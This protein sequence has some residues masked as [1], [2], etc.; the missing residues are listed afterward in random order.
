MLN[1]KLAALTMA[2]AITGC[3]Q[4]SETTATA[5]AATSAAELSSWVVSESVDPITDA[6][7]I[8]VAQPAEQHGDFQL[9]IECTGG[10]SSVSLWGD[11]FT[12]TTRGDSESYSVSYRFDAKPGVQFADW[13]ALDHWASP[14]DEAAF[15]RE[16]LGSKTLYARVDSD[17]METSEGKF[18]L[19]GLRE[20]LA[21]TLALCPALS[22]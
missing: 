3:A 5:A 12:P 15:L 22:T 20:A 7:T 21:K 10:K 1:L 11:R 2:F 16:M 9:R 18:H 19:A 8:T 4:K 13:R 6:K 17:A 14:A